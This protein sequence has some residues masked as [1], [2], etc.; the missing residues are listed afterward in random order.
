[1]TGAAAAHRQS[2]GPLQDG[3]TFTESITLCYVFVN[4]SKSALN[5]D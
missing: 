1:M 2:S 4:Q 5:F 3:P